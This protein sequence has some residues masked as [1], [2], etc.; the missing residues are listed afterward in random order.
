MPREERGRLYAILLQAADPAT[1][2]I[3]TRQ[4]ADLSTETKNLKFTV[5]FRG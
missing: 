3:W 5:M 4:S 1:L 2:A